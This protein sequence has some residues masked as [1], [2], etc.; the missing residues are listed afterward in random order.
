MASPISLLLRLDAR[1]AADEL[2][3]AFWAAGTDLAD[4]HDAIDRIYQLYIVFITLGLVASCWMFALDTARDAGANLAKVGASACELALRITPLVAL[5]L[6]ADEALRG[7]PVHMTAPDIAWLSRSIPKELWAVSSVTKSL[8]A[9]IAVAGCSGYLLGA[10]GEATLGPES[11]AALA[12]LMGLGAPV[13]A[14]LGNAAGLLRMMPS[15]RRHFASGALL[16]AGAVCCWGLGELLATILLAHMPDRLP[17]LPAIGIWLGPAC[18]MGVAPLIAAVRTARMDRIIDANGIYADMHALRHL[19]IAPG[20]S[21][22][23]R[24]VLRIRRLEARRFKPVLS[25]GSGTLAPVSRALI[26]H[27]RQPLPLAGAILLWGVVIIPWFAV[28]ATTAHPFMM[29]LVWLVLAI[30]GMESAREVTRIFTEDCRNRTIR[31]ALPFGR[32]RLLLA[33]SAP[34]AGLF[35]A[36]SIASVLL[37]SAD[38]SAS[39]VFPRL[40]IC[41][42]VVLLLVA[43]AVYDDPSFKPG[44][45]K[46]GPDVAFI[47]L[48]SAALLICGADGLLGATVLAIVPVAM[49]YQARC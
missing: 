8:I 29:N 3:W 7:C 45:K 34:A 10:F 27:M 35:A 33:D 2:R 48:C 22:T 39:M 18:A 43:T 1:H 12:V 37:L 23:Y 5:V 14:A 11:P 6:K 38:E 17:L 9:N 41:L 44:A 31:A 28:L 46:P 26:S 36:S 25:I 15:R 49:L 16:V 42:G 13:G 4:E 40:I 21:M 47:C 19:R 20:G 32:L 30:Q 24:K